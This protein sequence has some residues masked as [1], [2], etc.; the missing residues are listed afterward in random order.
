[1]RKWARVGIVI[2]LGFLVA[3][4]AWASTSWSDTQA[5]VTPVKVGPKYAT[6]SCGAVFGDASAHRTSVATPDWALTRQPC[7]DRSQRQVLAVVDL[8]IAGVGL[9]GL[10]AL[11]R[12]RSADDGEPLPLAPA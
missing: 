12:R 3:V 10:T 2:M 11:S 4:V 9:V 1:M 8:V 7:R 5:L 6:Y